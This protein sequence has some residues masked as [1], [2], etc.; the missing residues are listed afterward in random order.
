MNRQRD[1]LAGMK[2]TLAGAAALGFAISYVPS[3]QANPTGAQVV[4]GTVGITASNP[5]QMTIQQGSNK[6]VV[7]WNSFSIGANESVTFVQP[8]ATSA[9]LNRVLGGNASTIAGRL[10]ANGNVILVNPAGV[11]FAAGSSVNVGS[12]IAS[13]LNISDADFLASNYHFVGASPGALVNQGSLNA[14]SGGT[15]ALLG[16]TVSNSGTVAARLGTVALG[17]GSDIT[18]DFAGDGLTTLKINQGVANALLG[19]TGTLAADGGAVV[20]SAQS[21]DALAGTVINQQGIVRAQ[22]LTERN[23]HILL[24]GGANGVT[25]VSGTLDASGGAGLTGGRVDLTGYDVALLDGA[26]VDASGAAGGGSVRFG[27]GAAGADPGI[28]DANAIWMSPSAEIHAD[29]LTNG[30]GGL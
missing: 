10:Q 17:A 5:A 4:S 22:S 26:R 2:W 29:A 1:A 16:G 6:A 18:L 7:N 21:A 15:I 20:M 23:G 14:Q 3:L 30:T 27:G 25:Q 19:N 9:I 24:D 12:M 28:R 13:T 11:I 8:S